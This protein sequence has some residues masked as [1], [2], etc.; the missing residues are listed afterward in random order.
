MDCAIAQ[1]GEGLCHKHRSPSPSSA[2]AKATADATTPREG[3]RGRLN[4]KMKSAL[5]KFRISWSTISHSWL[6]LPKNDVTV[7]MKILRPKG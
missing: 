3:G 6:G 1:D 7:A 4:Y 5:N 2:F